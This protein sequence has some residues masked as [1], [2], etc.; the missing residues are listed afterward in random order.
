MKNRSLVWASW[1]AMTVAAMAQVS[2]QTITGSGTVNSVPVFT[3][4]STVGNSPISVSGGN[5]GIGTTTPAAALDVA[6]TQTNQGGGHYL[7][8]YAL[9]WNTADPNT[10][11]IILLVPATSGSAVNGSQ[12]A[13]II[14]SNRGTSDAWNLNSQ[15]YVSAQSAYTA[16]TG[17]ILPL[18]G[19][20]EYAAIPSLITCTYNG[21]MYI[22]LQTPA[23]NSMSYWSLSGNWSNGQNAQRP[24]LVALSAVS[25][26]S[27]LVGYESV[28]SQIS[29]A[30]VSNTGNSGIASG[31]VGIGTTSPTAKLEVAGNIKLTNGSG[32][33]MTFADGTTQTTAW[34]GTVCGGDYAESVDVSGKREQY[35]PGDVLVIDPDSAGKFLKSSEPYSTA[36]LGVYS[37]KP[38]TVGRR[39]MTPKSAD[40]VPMAMVGI[41][42]TKVS[43]ENGP[44][45]PGDLLV[46]A[47]TPGYAMKGTDRSRL[48]G[49]VIGKALGHL[50]S[51]KGVIE[52]GVTLQ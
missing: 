36:V 5:V 49:A 14:Q 2:A 29:I 35:E 3:G 38:G 42:P 52:V 20:Q 33:S 12:F 21:T 39:Q 47:S 46:S 15:W 41:V 1:M 50:E 44:I 30:S 37:T 48:V 7:L 10:G 22:G 26:L 4:T 40:E 25:N 16:N 8:N 43:A 45:R 32:A 9:G 34:T 31:N 24:I 27:T 28:G 23:G 13:G 17:S 6:G 11:D 18:S 51:G 19:R